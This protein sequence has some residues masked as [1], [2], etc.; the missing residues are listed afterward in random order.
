M[1]KQYY[2][3]RISRFLEHVV[4]CTTTAELLVTTVVTIE[5]C[6]KIWRYSTRTP[7]KLVSFPS[8]IIC[9]KNK[10]QFR[11]D[12]GFLQ[13]Y[14]PKLLLLWTVVASVHKAP[15]FTPPSLKVL[16]IRP[17]EAKFH[18]F[19]FPQFQQRRRHS[20]STWQVLALR[21]IT[22][23]YS[24]GRVQSNADCDSKA[25]CPRTQHA[26]KSKGLSVDIGSN[27]PI[28]KQQK[29]NI[30]PKWI[31]ERNTSPS[32][33]SHP[34]TTADCRGS[35]PQVSRMVGCFSRGKSTEG[36]RMGLHEENSCPVQLKN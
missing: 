1:A 35:L 9:K 7:W 19:A 30:F 26:N 4:A 2:D 14:H 24:T 32:Q 20:S 22:G 23:S 13:F 8:R 5:N 29:K 10:I 16:L 17:K 31:T 11:G 12:N 27:S 28:S 6:F 18:I 33:P 25:F 3:T 21:I 15:F 36:K 34:Q